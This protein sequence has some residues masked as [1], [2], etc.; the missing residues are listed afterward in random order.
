MET[1]RKMCEICSINNKDTR[2]TSMTYFLFWCFNNCF[3]TNKCRLGKYHFR[4]MTNF[5]LSFW[6]MFDSFWSNFDY[7]WLESFFKNWHQELLVELAENKNICGNQLIPFICYQLL[8]Q[9]VLSGSNYWILWSMIS[10]QGLMVHFEFWH[11]YRYPRKIETSNTFLIECDHA[12]SD[13][14]QFA[15]SHNMRTHIVVSWVFMCKLVFFERSKH[16]FR[17][18]V[19]ICKV[20]LKL[21]KNYWKW[22]PGAFSM[23]RSQLTLFEMRFKAIQL[24]YNH[25]KCF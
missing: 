9:K 17:Y 11:W 13:M 4:R 1:P 6:Q 12:C 18:A 22:L 25:Y 7:I 2:T 23:N 15:H 5:W 21:D 20:P 19:F 14:A 3:W 16:C 8:A 10:R 24:K